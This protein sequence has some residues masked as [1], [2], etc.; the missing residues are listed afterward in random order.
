MRYLNTYTQLNEYNLS[1]ENYD[2]YYYLVLKFNEDTLK[3]LL[4]GKLKGLVGISDNTNIINGYFDIRDILLVMKK[5]SV[6]ALNNIEKVR[7][8]DL[9]YLTNDNM[10]VLRRLYQVDDDYSTGSLLYQG[11]RRTEYFNRVKKNVDNN[12]NKLYRRVNGQLY[13]LFKELDRE[14]HKIGKLEFKNYQ[15][16]LDKSLTILNNEKVKYKR[17]ELDVMLQF[18]ILVFASVFENEGEVLIKNKEFIIPK[19]TFV[20]IKENHPESYTFNNQNE[21]LKKYIVELKEKYTVKILPYIKGD[22]INQSHKPVF[23]FIRY[24]DKMINK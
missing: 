19:D 22:I 10:K 23:S 12:L 4:S 3:N 7:Y 24:I 15:E 16:L 21:I 1:T 17:E 8:N 18:I 9:E 13:S 2:K 6:H 20:F 5:E 14:I 11:I